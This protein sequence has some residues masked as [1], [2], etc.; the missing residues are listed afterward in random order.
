[1]HN[2]DSSHFSECEYQVAEESCTSLDELTLDCLAFV[3]QQ[4][5]QR[6]ERLLVSGQPV[7]LLVLVLLLAFVS[8][9]ST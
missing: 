4:L 1:M 8:Q 3:T 6:Q 5:Q 7:F 2:E 9:R